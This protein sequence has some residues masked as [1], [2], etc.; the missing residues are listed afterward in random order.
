MNKKPKKSSEGASI[1]YTYGRPVN[2]PMDQPDPEQYRCPDCN[3]NGWNRTGFIANGWIVTEMSGITVWGNPC[4]KCNFG[5][6]S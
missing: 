2:Y 3:A 1:K 4:T 5:W 6:R